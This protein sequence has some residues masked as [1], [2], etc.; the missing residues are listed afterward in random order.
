MYNGTG[1]VRLRG[2]CILGTRILN[3]VNKMSANRG[4]NGGNKREAMVI[5]PTS[6]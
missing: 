1:I 6:V 3:E 2:A 4:T 5:V